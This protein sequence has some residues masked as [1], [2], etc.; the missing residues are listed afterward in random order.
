MY[1]VRIVQEFSRPSL[2][3]LNTRRKHENTRNH[4]HIHMYAQIHANAFVHTHE[5]TPS[6]A[7]LSV[8]RGLS[9]LI[10]ISPDLDMYII[11]NDLCLL[12]IYSTILIFIIILFV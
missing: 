12:D 6:N 1:N 4:V 9:A 5:Y 3:N 2:V 10:Y 11:A 7:Y 8:R